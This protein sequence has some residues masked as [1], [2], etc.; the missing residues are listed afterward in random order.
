MAKSDVTKGK[1]FL[2]GDAES[3]GPSLPVLLAGH[4]MILLLPPA[5]HYHVPP[6]HMSKNN[7][8]DQPD[9]NVQ[10]QEPK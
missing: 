1:D 9:W 10:N 2:K 8:A 7:R 3:P 5:P 6:Y 4:L